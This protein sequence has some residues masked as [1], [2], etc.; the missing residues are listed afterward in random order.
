MGCCSTGPSASYHRS[1]GTRLRW[2]IML[3]MPYIN[4]TCQPIEEVGRGLL[5]W[6]EFVQV[7]SGSRTSR[8]ALHL[9][10]IKHSCTVATRIIFNNI[11]SCS[12]ASEGATVNPRFHSQ[13]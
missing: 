10:E 4:K 9:L 12:D 5:P 13:A 1:S 2:K 8:L 11:T 7:S 6:C 3:A